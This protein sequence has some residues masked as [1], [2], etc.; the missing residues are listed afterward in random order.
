[1]FD[2]EGDIS[3]LMT[4]YEFDALSIEQSKVKKI[5]LEF[6]DDMRFDLMR[7]VDKSTRDKNLGKLINSPTIR[8]VSLK[9]SKSKAASAI[10]FPSNPNEFCDRLKL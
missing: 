10:F 7:T 8:A 2:L 5:L 9:I 1:M 4:E 6:L 3:V